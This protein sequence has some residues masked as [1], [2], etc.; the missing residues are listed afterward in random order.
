MVPLRAVSNLSVAHGPSRRVGS[1]A[2]YNTVQATPTAVLD[3]SGEY[4]PSRRVGSAIA[5]GAVQAKPTAAPD[6]PWL[7][8][9][10]GSSCFQL[11]ED[12]LLGSLGSDTSFPDLSQTQGHNSKVKNTP[13]AATLTNSNTDRDSKTDP[14]I[15]SSVSD[16]LSGEHGPS[17]R[18]GS[19]GGSAATQSDVQ[20][21]PTAGSNGPS[22]R[23]GSAATHSNVQATPT[24]VSDFSGEYGPSRRVGSAIAHRDVPSKAHCSSRCSVA[25]S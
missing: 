2:T 22:R 9:D 13:G 21:T 14:P 16:T 5:H 25:R 24:A 1:A 23:V 3:L 15:P 20:A 7:E 12:D 18:V 6:F 4:G 8:V 19:A 10:A 11:T 17:R